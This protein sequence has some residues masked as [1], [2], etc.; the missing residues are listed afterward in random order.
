MYSHTV[1]TVL[2]I[3]PTNK[4]NY[5][6]WGRWSHYKT[7]TTIL[8]ETYLRDSAKVYVLISLIALIHCNNLMLPL[9]KWT[10]KINY[11]KQKHTA[12]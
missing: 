6:I 10:R 4:I 3:I 11:Y 2:L 9:K 7:I 12:S 8:E 1:N 5:Y